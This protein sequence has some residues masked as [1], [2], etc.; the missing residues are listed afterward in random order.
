[1]PD[2]REDQGFEAGARVA[3]DPVEFEVAGGGGDGRAGNGVAEGDG[4]GAP[5]D[6]C[7]DAVLEPF[8]DGQFDGQR[9]CCAAA[10]GGGVG[11]DPVRVVVLQAVF[12]VEAG[13][14]Q[15][16]CRH[17]LLSMS[18]ARAASS[19]GV[20]ACREAMT[21]SRSSANERSTPSQWFTGRF[22]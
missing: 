14:A 18:V 10:G 11:V 5:G 17:P 19:A 15:F 2:G 12:L 16:Q 9:Q 13:D 7:S 20:S 4:V 1:L 6:G 21:G 22:E 3:V 8:A